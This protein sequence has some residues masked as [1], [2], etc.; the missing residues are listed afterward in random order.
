VDSAQYEIKSKAIFKALPAV[1][2]SPYLAGRVLAL[3]QERQ[4]HR[5]QVLL[6]RWV[7]AFSFTV[8]V[9]FVSVMQLPSHK[10]ALFAYQPYVIHV[11]LDEQELKMAASAE[12]ELPA[13]VSF[14]SMSAEVQALRSLK[15]AVDGH[16]G[17]SRLPFVVKSDRTGTMPLQVRIYDSNDKLLQTKTLTLHFVRPS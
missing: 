12:V 17:R 1:D 14:V 5:K 2:A 6:W 3:H 10:E 8:L 16:E 13:G 4:S 11:N 15:L 7:A 9:A